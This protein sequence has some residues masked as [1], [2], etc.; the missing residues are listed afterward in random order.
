[1]VPALLES[2]EDAV[3]VYDISDIPWMEVMPHAEG[4]IGKGLIH[5]IGG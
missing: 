2:M 5:C 1:M 4:W 3:H